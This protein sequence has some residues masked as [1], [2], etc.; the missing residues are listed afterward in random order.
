MMILCVAEIRTTS[1]L[2]MTDGWYSID[3]HCDTA[4][5]QLIESNKIFIGVKLAISG[6]ELVSPGPTTPLEKGADTFLKV[7]STNA[8]TLYLFKLSLIFLQISANSTRRARWDAKL[9]FYCVP[10]PFPI[11]LSSVLA[12]GG[13][14]SHVR[15]NIIRIFPMIYMEK[16]ADGIYL[17]CTFGLLCTLD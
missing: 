16:T 1:I 9:G 4:L 8:K 10:S 14:V 15:V 17:G 13:I 11:T 7:L 6:A 2:E 5:K 3:V 12:D